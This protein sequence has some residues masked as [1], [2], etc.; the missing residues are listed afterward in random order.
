MNAAWRYWWFGSSF[1]QRAMLSLLPLYVIG[2]ALA[3]RWAA[4]H[5]R[6]FRV[7]AA[8]VLVSA[9]WMWGLFS[10]RLLKLI[11]HDDFVIP[12]EKRLSGNSD[13]VRF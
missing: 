11:P 7:T 6:R 13:L 9:A 1:G 10:L 5:R 2:L 12:V 3:F 8:V 4:T